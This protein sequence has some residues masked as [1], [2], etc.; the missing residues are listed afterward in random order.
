[1]FVQVKKYG[2][3]PA[4]KTEVTISFFPEKDKNTGPDSRKDS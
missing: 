1:M 3:D 2:D 4:C